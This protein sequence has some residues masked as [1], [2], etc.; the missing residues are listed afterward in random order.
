MAQVKT[1]VPTGCEVFWNPGFNLGFKAFEVSLPKIN[2]G[3][4]VLH[5]ILEARL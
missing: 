3:F 2:L 1:W 5:S 4:Q